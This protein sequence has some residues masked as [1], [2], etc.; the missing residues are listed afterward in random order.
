LT[1][2]AAALLATVPAAGA[3]DG[4]YGR[5]DGDLDLGVGL[6]AEVSAEPA[7]AALRLT[8]HHFGMAG[9]AIG[10]ADPLG[11]RHPAGRTLAVVA[12][13]RPLFLPRWSNDLTRGPALLDLTLDAISIGLGPYFATAGDGPLG[14]ERGLEL[15]LG[16]GVPL[17]GRASGPW[18]EA[19][20]ALQCG[21]GA[22]EPSPP[23]RGAVVLL[24]AWHQ[25][26]ASRL[27]PRR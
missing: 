12:D 15:S 9:V 3:P 4:A 13:L 14:R 6:G 17:V 20:S 23:V 18:L 22:R 27:V 21:D 5:F 11:A 8:A 1:L 25:R 16:L 19:R 10:Y 24:L 7:R 2:G 26:V